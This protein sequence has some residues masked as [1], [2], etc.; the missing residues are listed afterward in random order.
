MICTSLG[1]S[2]RHISGF[3]FVGGPE[4]LRSLVRVGPFPRHSAALSS[5]TAHTAKMCDLDIAPKSRTTT[6]LVTSG[7]TVLATDVPE[8]MPLSPTN[9]ASFGLGWL[10]IR[11][12]DNT[13]ASRYS[14]RV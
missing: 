5:T 10:A 8:W 6:I 11:R 13:I 3:R 1:G 12:R 2:T 4:G 7:Y 14:P 9:R